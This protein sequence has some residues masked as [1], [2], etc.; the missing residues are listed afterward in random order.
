MRRQFLSSL[1]LVAIP[2]VALAVLYLLPILYLARNSLNGFNP[3]TGIVDTIT[4]SNYNRFVTDP[5]Y[6]LV[7]WRTIRI[8]LLVTVA[9]AVIGYPTSYFLAHLARRTRMWLITVL[10]V[11]LVTSAIVVSYGWL[12]L[13]GQQ[14]LI[15]EL[16]LDLRLVQQ[17]IQ[18]IYDEN[19]VVIGLVQVL[20]PFMVLA[21]AASLQG[22][23]FNLVRAA[24]SLGA[25]PWRAFWK[26]VFPL[27][28]PG[29]RT[30]SLLVFSSSMSAYAT[31]ALLGG[32]QVK[33][34]SYLIYEQATSVLNWPFAAS[35]SVLLLA[36]T[37]G[38]LGLASAYGQLQ[39]WRRKRASTILPKVE[40]GVAS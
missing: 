13:L 32:P 40:L 34:V 3:M 21:L 1:S 14:G 23:D 19:G 31:P 28:L 39:S 17:P 18:L 8:S 37:A 38:I 15:N 12:V 30:G 5:Y 35:I 29:L 2:L 25:S 7:L 10:L 11:P 26:I 9:C 20:L 27:S 36:V 16:L 6:L 24:R 33:V 4:T 22:L